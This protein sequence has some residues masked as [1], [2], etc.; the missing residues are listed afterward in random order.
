M[1]RRVT[2][3]PTCDMTRM[4]TVLAVLRWASSKN[5]PSFTKS[6]VDA[7]LLNHPF[8]SDEGLPYDFGFGSE[9][10]ESS[11]DTLKFIPPEEQSALRTE[12]RR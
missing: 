4:P 5:P 2:A 1:L 12:V 8:W 9:F 3:R 7:S 6:D 10:D 11:G